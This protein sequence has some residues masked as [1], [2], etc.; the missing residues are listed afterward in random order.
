VTQTA[1]MIVALYP[2][3]ADRVT[4]AAA[5]AAILLYINTHHQADA[6]TLMFRLLD[7][8]LQRYNAGKLIGGYSTTTQALLLRFETGLYCTVGLPTD[9]L[10]LPGVPSDPGTV[11]R[12][13]LPSTTTQNIVTQNGKAGVQFP[14]G[15]LNGPVLVTISPAPDNPLHTTLHQYGPFSDVKV[16]PETSLNTDLTV[17]LCLDAGADIPTVFLAHN[18]S[19]TDIAVLPRGGTISGLCGVT[20]SAGLGTAF[21]LEKN[22]DLASATKLVGSALADMLLPT[23]ANA[24]GG[25]IT[26]TTRKFSPFGGVDTGGELI[27]YGASYQY[28][29]GAYDVSPGFQ[30]SDYSTTTGWSTGSGAFGSL[31]STAC[32]I[33]SD[34]QFP[35][36]TNWPINTDLLLRT[37]FSLPAGWSTPLTISAAIDNDVIVY[38]NGHPLTV[39]G[40]GNPLYSF[41]ANGNY[42]F[43]PASGFVSHENCAQRG[44]LTFTAPASYLVTGDN[45][46]AIR[47]RDRGSVDYL[48]VEVKGQTPQ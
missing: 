48:D 27:P 36:R 29:I 15:S 41:P 1:Q 24:T 32:P 10:V 42:S 47:A 14:G 35:L 33:F 39:D 38:V 40:S 46:L 17:G 44:E 23:N 20:P 12:V 7:F 8:T 34:T 4:A 28:Q 31:G 22:G 37:T 11:N 25:G 6:Q 30:A 26:G 5:Y 13:V 2:K 16:S 45:V 18:I 3:G 9:G 21:N 19:E 43:D